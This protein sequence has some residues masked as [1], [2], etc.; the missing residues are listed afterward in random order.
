LKSPSFSAFVPPLTNS[1]ALSVVSMKIGPER[2][3]TLGT[4][5]LLVRLHRLTPRLSAVQF[6][7]LIFDRTS[8][9]AA[10]VILFLTGA[11]YGTLCLRTA[12]D[13][14]IRHCSSERPGIHFVVNARR[15]RRC[16]DDRLSRL[17]TAVRWGNC[18]GGERRDQKIT[19]TIGIGLRFVFGPVC[20]FDWF[21]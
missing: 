15:T 6:C 7:S 20:L 4:V 10:G 8:L 19:I 12:P 21:L 9:I 5:P 17:P 13:G 18:R 16:P 11:C 1:T 3:C 14:I 2:E